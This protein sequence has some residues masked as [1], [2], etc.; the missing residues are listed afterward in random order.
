M[1]VPRHRCREG[2]GHPF[3]ADGFESP[4]ARRDA[5]AEEVRWYIQSLN[6][7][8]LPPDVETPEDLPEA[9]DW[10]LRVERWTAPVILGAGPMPYHF[11]LDLEAA[12]VGRNR[13][14]AII[15][16]NLRLKQQH[17]AQ[18]WHTSQSQTE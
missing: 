18:S 12:M 6:G 15:D 2:L 7:I 17:E 16:T 9:L 10:L 3:L 11:M 14:N 13:A 8:D 4:E 5:I 1:A